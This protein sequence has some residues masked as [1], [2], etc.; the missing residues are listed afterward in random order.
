MLM[1]LG[2]VLRQ[3]PILVK[4]EAPGSVFNQMLM[5]LIGAP[6][7]LGFLWRERQRLGD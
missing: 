4:K 2:P 1:E 5:A 7:L 6:C 3:T